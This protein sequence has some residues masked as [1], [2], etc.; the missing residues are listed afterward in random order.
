MA[1]KKG[2]VCL[3]WDHTLVDG[4]RK[5]IKGAVRFVQRLQRDDLTVV[6]QSARASY[7]AGRREIVDAIDAA[8]L[9]N[10]NVATEKPAAFAYVDDRAVK[11]D[12]DTPDFDRAYREVRALV[13][14]P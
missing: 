13:E 3:D 2:T 6:V 11:V 1:T 5:L 10:V 7:P 4:D 12:P 8:G 14:R 9:R